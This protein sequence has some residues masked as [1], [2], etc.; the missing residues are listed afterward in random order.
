MLRRIKNFSIVVSLLFSAAIMAQPGWGP[1]DPAG[2][3]IIKVTNTPAATSLTTIDR[4]GPVKGTNIA[5]YVRVN[6]SPNINIT[7]NTPI[8]LS[9]KK[10]GTQTYILKDQIITHNE[11]INVTLPNGL[12]IGYSRIY[13]CYWDPKVTNSVGLC[14]FTASIDYSFNSS[15]EIKTSVSPVVTVLVEND[16][17]TKKIPIILR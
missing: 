9:I 7:N 15:N 13:Q 14:D 3:E 11:L 12:L 2:I 17:P 8:K 16:Q 5:I 1:T 10:N 6:Y 4:I